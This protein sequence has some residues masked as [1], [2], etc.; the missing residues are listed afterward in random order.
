MKNEID[1]LFQQ[2]M[3][4]KEFLQYAGSALLFAVGIG[5]ILKAFRPGKSQ[6]DSSLSYGGSAYGGASQPS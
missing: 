6:A 5:S 2:E 4:R 3:T 1:K